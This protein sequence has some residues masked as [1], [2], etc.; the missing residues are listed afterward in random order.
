MTLNIQLPYRYGLHGM[1]CKFVNIDD[2]KAGV[3]ALRT[4][5][6]L[7]HEQISLTYAK[8][9]LIKQK[10]VGLCTCCCVPFHVIASTEKNR[11]PMRFMHVLCYAC[12]AFHMYLPGMKTCIADHIDNTSDHNTGWSKPIKQIC[13]LS[14]SEHTAQTVLHPCQPWTW[15]RSS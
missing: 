5:P 11:V 12:M 15:R 4:P 8:L 7:L 1:H 13:S 14:G 9:Q 2:K 10:H 3:F 6:C